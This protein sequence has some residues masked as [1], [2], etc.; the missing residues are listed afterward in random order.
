M[1]D[2]GWVG[3]E[4]AGPEFGEEFSGP[5]GRGTES[6]RRE[7]GDDDVDDG[8]V[9]GLAVKAGRGSCSK[10]TRLATLVEDNNKLLS[11][12]CRF[13]VQPDS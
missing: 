1:N 5:E 2:Q 11:F 6:S 13:A 12:Y 8:D 3:A 4:E 7:V 10:S 9:F